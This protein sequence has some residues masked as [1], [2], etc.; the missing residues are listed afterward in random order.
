MALVMNASSSELSTDIGQPLRSYTIFLIV[1]PTVAIILRFW[2]RWLT[3]SSH[4]ERFW[5]DDWTALAAWVG[6]AAT[7]DMADTHDYSL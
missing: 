2:F 5:W 1:L 3:S 6:N 4:K 7:T